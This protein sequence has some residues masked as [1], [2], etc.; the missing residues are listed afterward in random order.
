[1]DLTPIS[2]KDIL[3]GEKGCLT[4]I[5]LSDPVVDLDTACALFNICL[6]IF[7]DSTPPTIGRVVALDE[8]H[9]V[10]LLCYRGSITC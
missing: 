9:N 7:V 2:R 3:C 6:S 10:G 1:M 4:I 5:D 8:A